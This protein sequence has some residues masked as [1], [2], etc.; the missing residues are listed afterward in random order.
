MVEPFFTPSHQLLKSRLLGAL[1]S[2]F[3]AESYI[4]NHADQF[5]PREVHLKMNHK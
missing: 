4:S 1:T 3:S 2:L 5:F